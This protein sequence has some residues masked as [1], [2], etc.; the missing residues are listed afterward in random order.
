MQVE[1]TLQELG[2]MTLFDVFA[3]HDP[4]TQAQLAAGECRP[5]QIGSLKL[6]SDFVGSNFGDHQLFFRY[7][8]FSEQLQTLSESNQTRSTM[9]SDYMT[10]NAHS[11]VSAQIYLPY[12]Q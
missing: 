7:T 10:A 9:W 2:D 12:L 4:C 1:G 6:D 3:V 11:E 5:T 8:W